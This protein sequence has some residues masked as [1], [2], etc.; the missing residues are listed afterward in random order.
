MKKDATSSLPQHE[1]NT[2]NLTSIAQ[3]ST[4]PPPVRCTSLY[5]LLCY[6]SGRYATRL[7]QLE[8]LT[9]TSSCDKS[10]F[11][12]LR[13]NYS[14]MRGRWRSYLSFRTLHSIKFVQFDL[15]SSLLV[16]V[17]QQNSIPPPTNNEYHY[18][19]APPELIPPIGENH[20]MHLYTH[21]DH[22]EPSPICF[23]KF[24]KK[25]REKLICNKAGTNEGW[26][27]QFIEGWDM[28]KIFGLVFLLFGIGSLAIG[29]LWSVYNHSIQDAFTMASYMIA[30]TAVGMGSLQAS[31][32]R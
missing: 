13:G 11:H 25:L 27:L 16:D 18:L 10:L 8:L 2:T 1:S 7:L 3:P 22:A 32:A 28:K 15:Y 23:E 12:A 14:S 29:V 19:P 30:M 5:L 9:E 26:G 24:P 4:T 20:L 21:P 6:P 31:L 17:K